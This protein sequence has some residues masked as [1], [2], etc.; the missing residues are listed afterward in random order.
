MKIAPSILTANF[1][2]LAEEIKSI[3]TADY[4]HV[5]VMDGNFV[6]NIS[7]GP[8][9]NAQIASISKIPLDVH[10]MVL[11]PKEWIESFSVDNVEYITIHYESNDYLEAIKLIKANHKK[12]GISVKPNTE[13]EVIYDVIKDVDLVLIMSVEPGFGG[14]KFMED[15]LEKVKKL[16]EYRKNHNLDFLIEIDGGINQD[17]YLKAVNAGV[18]I[19]VA[20]SYIFNAENRKKVISEMR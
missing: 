11:N 7:F 14:Q 5:D 16:V 17:T 19:L 9:I 6:P 4:I 15:Q 18:D 3:E 1:T 8:H 13:I 10:L 2:K 12:V 20:G